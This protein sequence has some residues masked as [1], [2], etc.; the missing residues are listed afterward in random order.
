M[1]TTKF[2]PFDGDSWEELIQ[3]C[4]RLKYESE[5]YQ[6]IHASQGDFAIE[7]FTRTGKVFHAIVQIITWLLLH[8]MISSE[9]RLQRM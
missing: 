9:T 7:G 4:L 6:S 5:Q 2:G 8:F 3:I 1:Y